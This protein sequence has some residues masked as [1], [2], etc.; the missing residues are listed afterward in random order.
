LISL[1]SLGLLRTK[2]TSQLVMDSPEKN[3]FT[4]NRLQGEETF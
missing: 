4:K 2:V 1:I 3:H